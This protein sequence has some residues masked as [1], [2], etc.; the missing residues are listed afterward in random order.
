MDGVPETDLPKIPTLTLIDGDWVA[1]TAAYW[2]EKEGYD[3]LFDRL[4]YDIRCYTPASADSILCVFSD[5]RTNNYRRDSWPIYKINRD[6]KEAPQFLNDS[7]KY[8]ED[9]YP[10]R[11]VLRLEADDLI[12][13]AVSK[14]VASAVSIDKDMRT[15]PGWHWNPNK[16]DDMTYVTQADAYRNFCKQ[17]VMGDSTDNIFGMVGKGAAHFEKNIAILPPEDWMDAIIE[18]YAESFKN[19]GKRYISKVKNIR[20]DLLFD[21]PY[22]YFL[23]QARCLRI[24]QFE[25]YN[26]DTGD[27]D[28]WN[29]D[30]VMR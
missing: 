10:S 24:L 14:G 17:L 25:D 18:G 29:L 9:N 15:I 28:L 23:S 6:D 1:Y 22:D 19:P 4:S 8:L 16:E 13:L 11:T 7:K 26:K 20:E 21:D 3:A 5:S 30:K 12:G 2:A 27:I